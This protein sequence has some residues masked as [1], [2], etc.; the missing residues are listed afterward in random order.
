MV[1]FEKDT[2]RKDAMDALRREIVD[3]S[4]GETSDSALGKWL[5]VK[6][7]SGV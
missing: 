4:L 1:G 7:D 6:V 2:V 3:D 5:S